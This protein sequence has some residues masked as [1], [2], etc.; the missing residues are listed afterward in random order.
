[1][2][3]NEHSDSLYPTVVV[4]GFR[5]DEG[6]STIATSR[7]PI[8]EIVRGISSAF[9]DSAASEDLDNFAS[10]SSSSAV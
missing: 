3:N 5:P 1:M 7:A 9:L 2:R 8:L 4:S 6:S 10:L